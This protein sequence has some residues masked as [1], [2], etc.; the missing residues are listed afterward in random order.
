MQAIA[1][2]AGGMWGSGEG[3][4]SGFPCAAAPAGVSEPG[5][6][7]LHWTQGLGVGEMASLKP[8]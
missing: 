8:K 1:L 5:T 2:I 4:S 6:A 7:M 3:A